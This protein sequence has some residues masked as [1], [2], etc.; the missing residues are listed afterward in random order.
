MIYVNNQ[1][2]TKKLPLLSYIDEMKDIVCRQ[3]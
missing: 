2:T 1:D 3:H